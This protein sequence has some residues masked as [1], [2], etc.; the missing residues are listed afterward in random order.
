MDG[1]QAQSAGHD[2]E[3]AGSTAWLWGIAVRIQSVAQQ[4]ESKRPLSQNG[5]DAC[6]FHIYP[7]GLAT[8]TRH[9]LEKD[10]IILGRSDDCDITVQDFSVSRRH[11]RFDRDDD[12]YLITDLE[13]T[14]GTY[15]NDTPARR[16][17]LENGDYLRV[18]KCLYRVLAGDNLEAEY[19]D[20]LYRLAILDALTGLNN[21]RYMMDYLQRE[22]ARSARY[23]RPLAVILFD[24]DHFKSIN[25]TMGYLA[26][27][28]TLRQLAGRLRSEI[29]TDDLLARYCDEEF[30]AIL[31]ETDQ[32]AATALAEQL[33]RAVATYPFT[34]EGRRHAV[35][36]SLGV[37]SIQAGEVLPP[38]E[39]IRRADERL[40]RAKNEGRNRVVS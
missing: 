37:A 12:G 27:D 31:T 29:C 4:V 38:Q 1:R 2:G 10:T 23:G 30:A 35:T 14:N 13:S 18:G 32:A 11:A 8:G 22:I 21:Q 28:L 40:G 3:F 39:L 16:T 9:P 25:D 24:I 5:R 20:E 26:G 33:R 7:T 6:L 34:F 19:H 36:I 17:P 15:V